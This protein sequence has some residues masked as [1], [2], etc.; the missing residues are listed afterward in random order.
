MNRT[1]SKAIRKEFR[2]LVEEGKV[3]HKNPETAHRRM[4]KAYTTPETPWPKEKISR[5]QKRIGQLHSGL[6]PTIDR[7]IK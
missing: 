4:K 1:I 7:L 5:R 3:K 6:S 2:Q